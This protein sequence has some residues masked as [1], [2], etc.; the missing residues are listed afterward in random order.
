MSFNLD[1]TPLLY[2]LLFTG[3]LALGSLI[4]AIRLELKVRAFTLG[5]SGKSL[6]GTM[7]ELRVAHTDM[8][9]FRGEMETYLRSVEK[10]L[11]R[12]VQHIETLRFNPFN[13]N[14]GNQ[15]FATALLSENGDGIMLTSIYARDRASIFA[16]QL[17]NFA[18]THELSNEEKQVLS[19]AKKI[20]SSNGNTSSS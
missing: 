7:G 2:I 1:Q 14:S 17:T 20:L 18:S 9:R 5:K 10:R 4:W 13:E 19:G 15:S 6:E 16:K 12:S 3:L 11:A 8:L